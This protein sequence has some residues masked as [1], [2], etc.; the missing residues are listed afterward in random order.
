M[1]IEKELIEIKSIQ[2]QLLQIT[3]D[4]QSAIR[5]TKKDYEKMREIL[6]GNGKPE[7]SFIYRIKKVED[8]EKNCIVQQVKGK[9]MPLLLTAIASGIIGI[10]NIF[11]TS[12][13]SFFVK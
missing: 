11:W 7:E 8:L 12:I 3:K 6:I 4:T 13:K 1:D 5:D 2:G 9:F 10:I